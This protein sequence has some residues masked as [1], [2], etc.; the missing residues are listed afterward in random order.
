MRRHH[1]F[2]TVVGL[3]PPTHMWL[4]P[5]RRLAV[6]CPVKP[7]QIPRSLHSICTALNEHRVQRTSMPEQGTAD[8]APWLAF[9]G[10]IL[11]ETPFG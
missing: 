6:R 5:E 1:G 3:P 11:M 7:Q 10:G 4:Y 8:W 2:E 9:R